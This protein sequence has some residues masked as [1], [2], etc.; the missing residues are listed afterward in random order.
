MQSLIEFPVSNKVIGAL[1]ISY[2]RR[3]LKKAKLCCYVGWYC[4]SVTLEWCLVHEATHNMHSAMIVAVQTDKITK[5]NVLA[6]IS[7]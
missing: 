6:C 4:V 3:E 5:K 7:I 2:I 1:G